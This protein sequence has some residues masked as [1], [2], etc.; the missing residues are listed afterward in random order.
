MTPSMPELAP[1]ESF[2]SGISESLLI[3][4]L[5][6][7]PL[8]FGCVES[9]SR[10]VLSILV[11][12]AFLFFPFERP[13]V[14]TR[15]YRTLIPGILLVFGIGIW[16]RFNP[17]PLCA[18]STLWPFT[19][20]SDATGDALGLWSIYILWLA[21]ASQIFADFK[22]WRRM[23]WAIFIIGA[24]V[25]VLGIMQVGQGN[26]EL[27][28][29]R[30]VGESRQPFGPFYD[31]DHAASLLC[32]SA[33]VGFGIFGSRWSAW[34]RLRSPG[35]QADLIA[36]QFLVFFLLVVVIAGIDATCSRGG[37]LSFLAAIFTIGILAAGFAKERWARW[38]I[39]LGVILGVSLVIAMLFQST[40]WERF[41]EVP[42]RVSAQIRLNMYGWGLRLFRDFPLTG[43]GFGAFST[44][45]PA[46]QAKD[47]EGLVQHVHNDW[48]EIL[49]ESGIV[50]F[51]AYVMGIALL[52]RGAYVSWRANTSR[53]MRFLIGSLLAA[54]TAFIVH[55]M[56]EFSFHI[57]GNAI[58][59]LALLMLLGAPTLDNHTKK[60]LKPIPRWAAVTLRLFAVSLGF[61]TIRP[62]AAEWYAHQSLLGPKESSPYY[63]TRAFEWDSKPEYQYYLGATYLNLS[64]SN[65]SASTLLLRKAL[66]HSES[67]LQVEPANDR[68]RYLEG[69]ILW[70]LGRI[71]D[72]RRLI[73][74]G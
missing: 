50:G 31:R 29:F 57:P 23:S 26:H 25:A 39:R 10:A 4:A 33:L 38:L 24:F 70:R 62:V 28:L 55:T 17:R 58:F 44:A 64:E 43:V 56:G 8:A 72:A 3:A 54:S 40:R 30:E 37:M 6:F 46:Y 65:P 42:I 12:L 66:I 27:Y 14:D 34:K 59:F 13:L 63:L 35:K 16:Q 74:P 69:A 71:D 1:N 20:L 9:W 45:Y 52:L 48:L 7:G 15:L 21:C 47:F 68:F 5:A 22:S 49:I 11:L 61:A 19:V 60:F 2:G 53:E 73:Q 51:L 32:I 18:P 41:K 67:A 36:T